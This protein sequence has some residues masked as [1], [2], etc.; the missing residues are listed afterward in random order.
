MGLNSL[1]P[2][3]SI[4]SILSPS[5]RIFGDGAF[6]KGLGHEGGALQDGI[7]VFI[8]EI[9]RAPLSFPPRED[10]MRGQPSVKS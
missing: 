1:L 9:Q 2:R 10:T 5:V 6:G 7:S 4:C 3:G 8:K